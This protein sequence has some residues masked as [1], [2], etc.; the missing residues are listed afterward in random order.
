[1]LPGTMLSGALK[2]NPR[3]VTE[4]DALH[5]LERAWEGMG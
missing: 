2:S 1:M 5:I 4:Q 3:D